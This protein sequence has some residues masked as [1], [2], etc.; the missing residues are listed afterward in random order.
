VAG[1]K[2]RKGV[3]CSVVHKMPELAC[4]LFIRFYFLVEDI[5]DE[6]CV[7]H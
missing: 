1:L 4:G 6:V 5:H 7:Y 3:L 2:T